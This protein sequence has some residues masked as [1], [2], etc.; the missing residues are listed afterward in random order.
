M[1]ST[2]RGKESNFRTFVYSILIV[3]LAIGL[4]VYR[5]SD[6]SVWWDEYSSLMHIHASSLR[7]FLFL[8]PLY[9]PATMPVYY[10]LEYLFWHYVSSTVIGLRLFSLLISVAVIPILFLLGKRLYSIRI[11]LLAGLLFALSPIHR[12][13]AQGIRMYV[14]L[15]FLFVLSIYFLILCSEESKKRY[16]IFLSVVNLLL[17]WTH[18]FAIIIVAVE[19]IWMFFIPKGDRYKRYFIPI[20]QIVISIPSIIYV[21][22]IKYYSPEQST[23]FHLPKIYELLGDIFADDAVGMTYQVRIVKEALPGWLVNL[24][25]FVDFLLLIISMMV[26]FICCVY[27]VRITRKD[28]L[29][30]KIT[31]LILFVLIPP[32][33]LY[34]LSVLWRPCIFPRYTLY[35]S[36]AL[37]LLYGYLIELDK[38]KYLYK[39]LL[40]IL[41]GIFCYQLYITLPG[42]QRT[43]WQKTAQFLEKQ[44]LTEM[45]RSP[46]FVYHAIN[47]DVF[48]YN[49]KD[50][51]I[52]VSFV[53]NIDTLKL[54]V[55]ELFQEES[56]CFA[57]KIW[58][59]YVSFYFDTPGSTEIEK[60]LMD[61]KVDYKTYD[62][63]GIEP[64]RVYEILFNEN[65]NMFFEERDKENESFKF[66]VSDLILSNVETGHRECAIQL[67]EE[68]MN[69]DP[70]KK[71]QY[72]NLYRALKN[73]EDISNYLSSLRYYQ[74]S[75]RSIGPKYKEFFLKKA[76]QL[77]KDLELAYLCFDAIMTSVDGNI[78][79]TVEKLQHI[80]KIYPD[81]ALPRIAL[82]V[83]SLSQNR[84]EE[85]QQWFYSVLTCEEGT[86]RLWKDLLDYIFIEKDYQKAL[87]EYYI[88]KKRDVFVEDFF[89]EYLI[90][91]LRNKN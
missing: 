12:F 52:P 65:N 70:L 36:L 32:L 25:P 53:E 68:W 80:V 57:N 81:L 20:V 41:I 61:N 46:V 72:Q 22:K 83:I 13:F 30:S 60:L 64:I 75:Q 17:L 86:Y 87:G 27:V 39:I 38:N 78:E 8:N 74:I 89:E 31:L 14:L 18:P 16:L 66:V 45:F 29:N 40:C 5:I 23:W 54:V 73:N 11:G 48:T 19:M 49:L 77:D 28:E 35:S 63:L 85:S 59:V 71:L 37:Y 43:N 79:L 15:T 91:K 1:E 69:K 47:S 67:I 56:K 9:D 34:I 90:A 55:Q 4:R 50:K 3:F 24:H 2:I 26:V 44:Q 58:F 10:V 82:G 51:R 62:F 76:I 84:E 7:E 21:M 42:P 33:F 88:L 6:E